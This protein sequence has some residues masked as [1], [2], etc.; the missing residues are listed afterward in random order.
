M[1]DLIITEFRKIYTYINDE[2]LS[3]AAQENPNLLLQLM[4]SLNLKESTR[5]C[6][7]MALGESPKMEYFDY[8][9]SFKDNSSP[10]IREAAFMSI[11]GYFTDDQISFDKIKNILDE[12]LKS[13]THPGVIRQINN[14]LEWIIF[15][16]G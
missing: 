2:T 14:L 3:L 1:E 15:W 4:T 5:A 6:I 16:K 8:I 12:G 10:L 7:L 11:T 13:E 9:L